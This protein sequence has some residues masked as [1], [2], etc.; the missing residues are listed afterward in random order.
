MAVPSGLTLAIQSQAGMPAQRY[1]CF[2]GYG[3]YTA[4][5]FSI[6]AEPK[7]AASGSTVYNPNIDSQT[8]GAVQLTYGGLGFEPKIVKVLN[9]TDRNETVAYLNSNIGSSGANGLKTV[10]AGTRTYAAHG[11]AYANG[12]LTI[13]VATAGP[14]TD[15]DDFVIEV[16]G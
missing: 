13:T 15:N 9:L 8:S 14:I 11:V 6:T 10:A 12:T 1:A 3:T 16:F 2:I 7:Y 4:A 5:D